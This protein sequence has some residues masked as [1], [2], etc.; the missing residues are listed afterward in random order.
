MEPLTGRTHQI[1]IHC[2]SIG[3]P[4]TGDPIYATPPDPSA[5]E[6]GLQYHLLHAWQ[7]HFRHPA[8]NEPMSFTASPPPEMDL[9]IARLGAR[10]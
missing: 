10:Q 4:L 2:A 7:L 6:I 9:T 5:K 3:H 8:T 1:R